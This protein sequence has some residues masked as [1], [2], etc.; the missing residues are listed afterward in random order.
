M[1]SHK[2]PFLLVSKEQKDCPGNSYFLFCF[3]CDY[4]LMEGIGSGKF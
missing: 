3:V 4:V 2:E 1:N